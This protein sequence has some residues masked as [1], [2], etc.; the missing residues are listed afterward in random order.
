MNTIIVTKPTAA[1]L[2]LGILTILRQPCL[3]KSALRCHNQMKI[4]PAQ[5]LVPPQQR[6]LQQ[7]PQPQ[8]LQQLLLQIG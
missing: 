7:R 4:G 5:L 2:S 1:L 3:L 6:P 8:R